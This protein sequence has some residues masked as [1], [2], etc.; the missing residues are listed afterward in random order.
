M[1]DASGDSGAGPAG[2]GLAKG[3]AALPEGEP[4]RGL[5]KKC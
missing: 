1:N 2:G 5:I 3:E 4:R